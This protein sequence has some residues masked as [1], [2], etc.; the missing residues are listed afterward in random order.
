MRTWEWVRV[1]TLGLM[2]T[3]EWAYLFR[4]QVSGLPA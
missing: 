2:S 3:N 1:Q 4:Q